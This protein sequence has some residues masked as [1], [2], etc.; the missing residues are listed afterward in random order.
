LTVVDKIKANFRS[1]AG[2]SDVTPTRPQPKAYIGGRG[3]QTF[4]G[5]KFQGGIV[6]SGHSTTINHRE[7]RANARNVIMD[8]PTASALV[9]RRA[10]TVADTGLRPECNPMSS[11]LGV[12]PE[13]A[14]KWGS[15][16]EKRWEL[17]ARDKKQNRSEKM[18]FNATQSLYQ[19][20]DEGDGENFIRFYY[21]EDNALI[22]PLQFEPLDVNQIRG[23]AFTNNS[24][25]LHIDDGIKRDARGRETSYKIWGLDKDGQYKDETIPRLS[26]NRKRIFMIHGF[27]PEL[28]GQQRGYSKIGNII[29]EFQQLT[30]FTL[31]QI[32]KAIHQSQL[33]FF[34]KNN[35]Q[36]PSN[37]M[38]DMPKHTST[39]LGGSVAA[40]GSGTEVDSPLTAA[41]VEWCQLDQVDFSQP[42]ATNVGNLIQGDEIEAVPQTAPSIGYKEFV[43]AF[44]SSLSAARG[45]P[46]E[47]LKMQ[48]QNNYSASRAALVLFWRVVTIRRQEMIT[49]YLDPAFEMWLS[50]EIAA[51]RI[52]APGWSDPVLKSA[53]LNK[54]WYGSPMPNID[55]GRE[56]NANKTNLEINATTI[57]RVSRNL[58]GSS[59]AANMA[60]NT[61]SFQEMPVPPWAVKNP[62]GFQG[63]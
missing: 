16:V 22:N 23:S 39:G 2:L 33:T 50:E 26:K 11:I 44:T 63:G 34:T 15:D 62:G 56:A 30:S 27:V 8:N 20:T 61:R 1:F 6:N 40:D 48:F 31:A 43:D 60:K 19:K 45:M 41:E 35:K 5:G 7:M 25:Q 18:S 47:V 4:S 42:G 14:E 13:F 49:D 55:P 24:Y 12:T 3:G 57:D 10:D 53:W 51:G 52:K 58:N 21:S 59:G 46:H 54:E 29:Q 38:D 37:F 32:N 36:D 17:W 28:A 9:N